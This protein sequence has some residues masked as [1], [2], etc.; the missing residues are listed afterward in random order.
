MSK[1]VVLNWGCSH[2]LGVREGTFWG[3]NFSSQLLFSTNNNTSNGARGC[4]NDFSFRT[5][6]GLQNELRTAGL[7]ICNHEDNYQAGLETFPGV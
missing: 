4:K 1:A 6:C 5:G 2:P 7:K 3:A